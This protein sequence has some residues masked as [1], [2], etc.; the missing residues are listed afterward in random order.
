MVQKPCRAI[1]EYNGQNQRETSSPCPFPETYF[2][3]LLVR[4]TSLSFLGVGL[5]L[6]L[7]WKGKASLAPLGVPAHLV[8]RCS[9]LEAR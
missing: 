9:T 6:S 5:L 3:F 7:D 4:Q 2:L 1:K 8:L